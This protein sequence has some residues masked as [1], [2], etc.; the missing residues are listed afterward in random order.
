MAMPCVGMCD[1]EHMPT[2]GGGGVLYHPNNIR[3]GDIYPNIRIDIIPYH[4]Y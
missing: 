4:T 1:I 2:K 3:L